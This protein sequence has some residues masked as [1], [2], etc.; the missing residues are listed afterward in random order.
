MTNK[1]HLIAQTFHRFFSIV[2]YFIGL[3]KH[4]KDTKQLEKQRRF[5][6]SLKP[7]MSNLDLQARATY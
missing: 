6:S 7:L 2:R 1:L 4:W 5:V 3:H